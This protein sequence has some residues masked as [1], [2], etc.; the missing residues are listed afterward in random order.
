MANITIQSSNHNFQLTVGR[1]TSTGETAANST[2]IVSNTTP[3][4]LP[5]ASPNTYIAAIPAMSGNHPQNGSGFAID[6]PG[7]GTFY[8]TIWASSSTS[9]NYSAMAAALTVLKVQF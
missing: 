9:H 4:A 2:D 1:A 6:N 3:L 5:V 8:Y 7:A